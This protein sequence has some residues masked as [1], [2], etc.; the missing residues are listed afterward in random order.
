MLGEWIYHL[1]TAIL[2]LELDLILSP[3]KV[4]LDNLGANLTEATLGIL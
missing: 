4:P 1:Q 2:D 3:K